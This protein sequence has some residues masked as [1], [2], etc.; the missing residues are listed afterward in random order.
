MNVAPLL[1]IIRG[2]WRDFLAEAISS[3]EMGDIR[4]HE[5]TGRHLG[6]VA[7]VSHLEDLLGRRLD[8][9][10]PEEN[11]KRAIID[12]KKGDVGSKTI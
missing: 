4:K 1:S 7:F 5:Q 9:E 12:T 11:Q 3:A 6:D 8:P 10:N 2:D